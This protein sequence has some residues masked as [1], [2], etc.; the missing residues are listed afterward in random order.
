MTGYKSLK[1]LFH[2]HPNQDK[3]NVNGELQRRLSAPGTLLLDYKIV[4]DEL[5]VVVTNDILAQLERV[6]SNEVQ[7]TRLWGQLPQTA[8]LHY[9]Y[10]LLVEEIQSTNE[11]ENVHST[12]HEIHEALVAAR[13]QQNGQTRKR[14][15]EMARAFHLFFET[16]TSAQL[17]TSLSGL[18]E[19]YDTLLKDEISAD[20]RPDGELFRRG[21]VSIIDGVNPDPVHRGASSEAEIHTRLQAMLDMQE[22]EGGSALMRALV[23]HFILEH[24]HPFYDGNGRFGRFLLGLRLKPLLSA[25]TALS[26]SAEI[27]REKKAYYKAFKETEHPLNHGEA[28]FF[29][30]SM[31]RILQHAQASRTENLTEKLTALARLSHVVTDWESSNS[32][33]LTD[34]EQKILFLL[35]QVDLFGPRSGATWDEIAQ[36]LDRTK[37]TVRSPLNSL[38]QRGLATKLSQKPLVVGLTE[39]GRALLGLDA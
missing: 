32:E 22:M 25:P 31:I 27:M 21:P 12:R 28:T 35:G 39:Q 3:F 19:L 4:D 20:D 14:F 15:Q 17:P 34:Y 10:S 7:L 29:V 11:I 1:T 16:D 30:D 2:Q 26:L 38:E 8:Q 36:F 13:N 37:Q 5:F 33:E 9:L 18:R 23:E 24:T 6:W